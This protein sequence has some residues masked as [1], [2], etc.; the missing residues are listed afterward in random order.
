MRSRR[1]LETACSAERDVG[2]LLVDGSGPFPCPPAL[3]QGIVVFVIDGNRWTLDLREG[4]GT[5]AKGPP[6][7]SEKADIT[8][9]IKGGGGCCFNHLWLLATCLLSF[10]LPVG[11]ACWKAGL[12]V[13]RHT[14]ALTH[15]SL[16]RRPWCMQMP[17]LCGW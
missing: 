14:C 3:V 17:T 5:L 11:P 12:C 8:L 9:T 7:E 4:K 1:A 13:S 2:G 6:P 10:P 16:P 15:L